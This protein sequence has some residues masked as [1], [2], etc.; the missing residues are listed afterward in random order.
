MKKKTIF[1]LDQLYFYAALRIIL[2]C[3]FLWASYDK[4][5]EPESFLVIVSNYRILPDV[6]ANPVAFVLPWVEA[7][8]G[9]MLVTGYMVKGSALIVNLLM[10]IFILALLI[11]SFRGIDISC[12]CFSSSSD[13]IGDIYMYLARDFFIFLFSGWVLVHNI[14]TSN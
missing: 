14:N 2:G 5:L 8:C 13:H 9:I 7:V 6:L 4:I 1:Q 11:S 12:G 3:I 10:I